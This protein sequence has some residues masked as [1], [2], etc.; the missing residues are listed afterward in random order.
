VLESSPK[1]KAAFAK[2]ISSSY[3]RAGQVSG[4]DVSLLERPVAACRDDQCV[5]LP[6]IGNKSRMR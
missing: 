4:V 5:F 2:A 3:Y 1:A 6:M